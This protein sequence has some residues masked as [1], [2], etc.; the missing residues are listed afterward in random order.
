LEKNMPAI[1]VNHRVADFKTFIKVYEEHEP[2]RKQASVTNSTVWQA[3][4][5]P[6]NVFAVIEFTD[7]AEFKHYS[8]SAELKQ[9]L[10]RA[11]IIGQPVM[12]A[13]A[14]GLKYP[15]QASMHG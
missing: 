15:R 8:D 13:L 6:N 10:G 9:A 11:G 1:L 3:E 4:G 2:L 7:P 14:G 12:T 5:D